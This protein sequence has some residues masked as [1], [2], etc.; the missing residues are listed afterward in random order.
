MSKRRVL[1]IEDDPDI[2]VTMKYMLKKKGYEVSISSNGKEGFD[3]IKEERPD[4]VILD[5]ILPDLA[6]EE[7]CREIRKDDS[8]KDT[9][10][11][12]VTAKYSDVDKV[13]GRVIGANLYMT[14]PFDMDE[15]LEGVENLIKA[16]GGGS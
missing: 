4:L 9:P 6:G 16:A 10:V 3:K 14:K 12:M 5:L 11:I 7:V 13:V 2:A 8:L 15:L 1:V